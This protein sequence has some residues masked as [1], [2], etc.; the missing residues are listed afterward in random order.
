[1]NVPS[2]SCLRLVLG[3]QLNL[4]HSWF[5]SENDDVL[6]VLAEL[7]QEAA[8]VRHHVQKV[9]AFFLAMESFASTLE[10]QGHKVLYLDLDDSAAFDDLE[11]LV[12][13]LARESG[14]SRFEYQRP[15]EFRLV[16]QLEGICDA[17]EIETA[18]CDSEHFLLPFDEI[19]KQFE[20]GTA[21]RMEAFYRRMRRKLDI[22]VDSEGEPEGGE[23]NYDEKNRKKLPQDQ[24]LPSQELFGNDTSE[25]LKRIRRHEVET[26]GNDGDG[27]T[28]WP[29][30]REQSL[31]LLTHFLEH[32]LPLFGPYQDAMTTRGWALFHSRLSFSMNTKMLS[33]AEVVSAVLDAWKDNDSVSL[34]SVEGFVRQ[35]IGWREYM[36]GMYW[37]NMPGY[38]SHNELGHDSDLPGWYWSG[39]TRMACV[40]HAIGQSLDHAYAHH[41]QRLMV[42]GNFAL[43][44]GVD[45]D[46]VDQWYLG[47]YAD[48]IEWVEMPNTRGMSQFAD[49]GLVASKPYCSSG[50]YI[51]RMSDYCGDCHYKVGQ[52]TGEQSCPFNSLYWHFLSRHESALSSN[53]RM[54]MPYR[55]W[56]KMDKEKK[57]QILETAE[58]FLSDIENL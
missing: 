23:W 42:T 53:P 34:P 48:A 17:L 43:L 5:D 44:A 13:E 55:N 57:Q 4:D 27:K 11:A 19:D 22:L 15:D 7:H 56:E 18:C 58:N 39:D 51:K 54:A 49:G 37:A 46:Q 28:D 47:I 40:A 8:Y 50:Q 21:H 29:V 35:I 6:Y 10:E 25:V 3:D 52:R 31:S 30:N 41:I 36:R 24:S 16:K 33:P 26:I 12:V 32:G 20:K 38:A 45:P 2:C 1:M 14:A 9:A